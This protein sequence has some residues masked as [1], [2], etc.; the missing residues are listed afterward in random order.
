M[1][2]QLASH[3]FTHYQVFAHLEQPAGTGGRQVPRLVQISSLLWNRKGRQDCGA[4]HGAD[5]VLSL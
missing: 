2:G 1:N 4:V 3:S 5:L